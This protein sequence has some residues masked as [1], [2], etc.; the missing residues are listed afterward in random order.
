M[1]IRTTPY[2]LDEVINILTIRASIENIK[3][4]KD[5]LAELG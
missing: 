4:S 2:N 3:L 1:I 5:A